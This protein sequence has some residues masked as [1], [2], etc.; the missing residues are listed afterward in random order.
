MSSKKEN[1]ARFGMAAKGAV[2]AL[3]GILTALSAFG[4]GGEKTGSKGAIQYLAEQSYGQILLVIMGIGLLGYVFWRFYQSFT[5][6]E[7]HDNNFKGIAI[8]IAYFISGLFY[9]ALAFYAFKLA[10]GSGGSSGGNSS[11]SSILN[12]E[13][14]KILGIALA[15]ILA[16]KAIYE[17]YMAYSEKFKKDVQNAG[18]DNDAQSYLMKW[19]R[20]GFTARGI[21]VGI[22]A[23]LTFKA[24]MQ[25]SGDKINTQTDAMSYIQNEF[26]SI[27]LGI[28]ALGLIG[29]GVF[30]F[31]KAKYPSI[32]I[33]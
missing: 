15:V 22:M 17:F 25:S 7:N 29:Y 11:F 31:I 23:Y 14:G 5:D 1:F 21:V 6:P 27:V 32:T 12:S 19:G 10:F 4:M 13:Y 28:I 30:M 3:L 16:I 24:S 2:Y 20:F 26:G 8:R 18:L 9:G 33:R